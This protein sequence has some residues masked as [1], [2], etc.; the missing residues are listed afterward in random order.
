MK[1]SVSEGIISD[2]ATGQR[3][4]ATLD[5][6]VENLPTFFTNDGNDNEE[7]T[8]AAEVTPEAVTDGKK[9]INV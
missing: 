4:L 9:K 1:G 3:E 2:I 8:F 7:F 5:P 6:Q